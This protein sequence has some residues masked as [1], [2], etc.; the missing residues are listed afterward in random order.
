MSGGSESGDDH[1]TD[2]TLSSADPLLGRTIL[3]GRFRLDRRLG[4]GGMGT[5]YE[6]NQLAV[7]RS[8]AV[9]VLRSDFTSHP[10]LRDRFRR[11]AEII[12]RLRHPHTIALVDYGETEDGMAVMVTEL[13]VGE[14]LNEVM[15]R[16]GSLSL[17]DS[18]TIV[19]QVAAS[20]FEAHS[21]GL[22]HRDLKPANIFVTRASDQIFCKVLD[23]G[24]ARIMDEGATRLTS[25]GQVFGTPR[26]MAPEQAFS[27]GE[28][29]ARADLYSLGLILFE[30]VTGR[31]PFQAQTAIQFL[32]AHSTE[33]PP[34]LTE[35]RTDVPSELEELVE[36]LL[37][38]DPNQR[39]PDADTVRQLASGL[40][41]KI[42][43]S[44]TEAVLKPAP[45][46]EARTA[47]TR[48]DRGA[49]PDTVPARRRMTWVAAVGVA[50]GLGLA[51]FFLGFQR[52]SGDPTA[53]ADAPSPGGVPPGGA[54]VP[55]PDS[56]AFVAGPA[57]AGPDSELDARSPE[58]GFADA[59]PS[60]ARR[61]R[62][63]R[64][65][66]RSGV[67]SGPRGMKIDLEEGTVDRRELARSCQD[68]EWAGM[69]RLTTLRCPADCAILVDDV[70]AGRTPAVDRPIA[71]G[72]RV[73][74]IYCNG[75][76][77]R[78]LKRSFRPSKTLT[79][80]CR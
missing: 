33:P 44:T 22:V 50:V 56:M 31:S 64:R 12:G 62:P 3:E 18:L 11:E 38:K 79:L 46:Q 16:M 72:R 80:A 14:P 49:P 5:V 69:S 37:S 8:V 40:R 55:D 52:S 13:L 48:A 59:A 47:L 58:A 27:T 30:C 43:G 66:P 6:A 67:V 17:V 34:K 70:C 39:P 19:E 78:R 7:G 4:S 1:R 71:P 36:S 76:L 32:A 20:L 42:K 15:D 57:D 68:S 23:F 10:L 65:R 9:K 26:Y 29:D 73:V 74:R 77:E 63:R 45:T 2:A 24:I 54:G 75:R 28:V 53:Y 35:L 51:A 60:D 61:T 21:L 41:A 25:T